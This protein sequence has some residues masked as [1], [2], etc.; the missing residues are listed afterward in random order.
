VSPAVLNVASLESALGASASRRSV[1]PVTSLLRLA[2][3]LMIVAQLGRIPVLSAGAKEAPILVNDFF[4]LLLILAAGL[5]AARRQRLRLDDT[6][7]LALVFAAIGAISALLAIPKF[8]L[9]FFELAFSAAYLLRWLAY[10]AVYLVCIN[11]VRREE[12]LGVWN[13]LQLAVLI[14]AGFGIVQ[15][16]FLPGFAQ[17]VYPSS[18][19]YLDWDPQGHRLVS[20]FLDPNF[21]GALITIALLVL[22]AMLS[23][24]VPVPR[25]KLLLLFTALLLTLSRSSFLA[26]MVGGLVI[27][28]V[29]G[30][31]RRLW[32]FGALLAILLLPALPFLIQYGSAF[33]KF[34]IDASALTRVVSWLSAIEVFLDNPILGVGFNTYGF[35]QERYGGSILGQSS[36]GLDGGILFIVV[37]TGVVGGFVYVLMYASVLGRCRRVWR[38]AGAALEERALCLGVAAASVALVVHSIFLNSLLYPFLMQALWTLWGLA[39]V[40][41]SARRAEEAAIATGQRGPARSRLTLVA[42]GK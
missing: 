20:T 31:S 42:I 37:M 17:I 13:A 10:F 21:A 6:A 16:I 22:L 11:F 4:V 33:N 30:L 39:H 28:S 7:V 27:A 23:L 36:F 24:G 34:R 14:F 15:S 8:G 12:V 26:F 29:R 5:A 9:T 19:L 38:D 35:V 41:A 18:E 25:W 2:L 3:L 40:V 1:V 32:G